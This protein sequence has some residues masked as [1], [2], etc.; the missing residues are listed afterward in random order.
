MDPSLLIPI[1]YHHHLCNPHHNCLLSH[2][3]LFHPTSSLQH[4]LYVEDLILRLPTGM[5]N[6]LTLTW[7]MPHLDLILM[8][9]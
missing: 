4:L 3:V 8:H 6:N 2:Q 1:H 5:L 7:D 9:K